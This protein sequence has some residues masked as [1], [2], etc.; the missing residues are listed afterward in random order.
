[1][2]QRT[3]YVLEND[4]AITVSVHGVTGPS[5]LDVFNTLLRHLRTSVNSQT[6]ARQQS[7][8][9][10]V[11]GDQSD[12]SQTCTKLDVQATDV[13]VVERQFQNAVV[14]A[15][16]RTLQHTATTTTAT[17]TTTTTTILWALYRTTCISRHTQLRT[18][19]FRW[20]KVLLPRCPC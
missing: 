12:S 9:K 7:V 14:N 6:V 11:V 20:S 18:G 8:V 15:I 3:K 13:D 17:T 10:F 5:V 1:M 16:G 19:G 4:T 2:C